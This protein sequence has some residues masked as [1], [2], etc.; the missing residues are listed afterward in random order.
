MRAL[1]A[2]LAIAAA[3]GSASA[4]GPGTG[5]GGDD[6]PHSITPTVPA[7]A[8]KVAEDAVKHDVGDDG[9]KFRAVGASLVVS[10]R[11]GMFSE[12]IEG[13]LALVCGEYQKQGQ[14]D[15]SWFFVAMKHGKVLWTTDQTSDNADDAHDSCAA[16]GLAK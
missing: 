14:T 3:A 13:P 5:M 9:L 16:A 1:I 11:R 6:V 15:Y 10:L 12:P 7:N 2:A 4:M 8:R